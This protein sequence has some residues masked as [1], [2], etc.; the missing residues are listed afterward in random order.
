MNMKMLTIAGSA[1]GILA[2]AGTTGKIYWPQFG[3]ETPNQH[4][5]DMDLLRDFRDEWRCDEMEEA[6]LELLEAEK[7]GDDSVETAHKIERIRK[8]M[9]EIDC[10]RFEDFD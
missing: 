7:A 9:D 2:A 10:S 6:L 5:A 1:L 8:K 4:A 3:W